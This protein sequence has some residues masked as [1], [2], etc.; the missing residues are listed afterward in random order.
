M[1]M[2]FILA[3]KLLIT[4]IGC[5]ILKSNIKNITNLQDLDNGDSI[6]EKVRKF[7]NRLI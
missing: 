1:D 6:I 5:N 2:I 4:D 3:F 7:I